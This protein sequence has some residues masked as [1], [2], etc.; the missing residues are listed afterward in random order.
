MSATTPIQRDLFGGR[1]G[2]YAIPSHYHEA[3][4]HSC[5][6]PMIFIRTRNGKAMPLSAATIEVRDGVRY[7][8][9]HFADCPDAADWHGTTW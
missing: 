3:V 1:V 8:L 7:A 6:A 5:G 4:C 9:T 2:E